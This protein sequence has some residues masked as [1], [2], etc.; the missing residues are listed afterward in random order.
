MIAYMIIGAVVVKSKK[1]MKLI[2]H[3]FLT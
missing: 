1:R 3:A 2:S